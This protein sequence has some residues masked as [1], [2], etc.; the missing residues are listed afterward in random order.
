MI[1][2]T[3]HISV[4]E[5]MEIASN[6]K[7]PKDAWEKMFPNCVEKEICS[8]LVGSLPSIFAT[9]NI[10]RRLERNKYVAMQHAV[11]YL[12]I[13]VLLTHQLGNQTTELCER[14]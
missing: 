12:A 3:Y 8:F 2:E 9:C 5:L 11:V 4:Q 6:L 13:E 1:P 14:G 10:S 7:T